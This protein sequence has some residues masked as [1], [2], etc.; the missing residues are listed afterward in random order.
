MGKEAD[1]MQI[2][3]KMIVIGLETK[4]GKLDQQ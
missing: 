4:Q 2:N 1:N 3:G